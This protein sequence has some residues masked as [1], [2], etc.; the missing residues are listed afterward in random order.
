[1]SR[2]ERRGTRR[3]WRSQG[4]CGTAPGESGEGS[5]SDDPDEVVV[6]PSDRFEGEAH[7]I[8]ALI[9]RCDV[10]RDMPDCQNVLRRMGGSDPGPI[11]VE[12]HIQDPM[13]AVL[14]RP[15]LPGGGPDAIGHERR[16][17]QIAARLTLGPDRQFPG[18]ADDEQAPQSLPSVGLLELGDLMDDCHAPGQ[19]PSGWIIAA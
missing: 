14:D 12:G 1:M 9:E 16:G 13:Q 15:V 8:L 7:G 19:L 5:W 10:H 18:A 4:E 17:C 3:P 11:L 2:L 6:V